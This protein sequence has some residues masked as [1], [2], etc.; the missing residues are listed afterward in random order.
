[1]RSQR[2]PGKP[3]VIAGDRPLVEW[4]V[5]AAQKSRHCH[6]FA[7]LTPADQ[8]HRFKD[9]AQRYQIATSEPDIP[10]GSDRVAAW[11]RSIPGGPDDVFVN[12]QCDEPDITGDD[13]DVLI[14]GLIRKRAAFATLSCPLPDGLLNDANTVKVCVDTTQQAVCFSRSPLD[15]LFGTP[16][17]HV[18]VYAFRRWM[19]QRFSRLGKSAG[20]KLHSLEQLRL[21]DRGDRIFVFHRPSVR[22]AINTSIDLQNFNRQWHVST[23][24]AA[25]A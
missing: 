8:V 15:V 10:T 20:E 11:A 19:L 16:R 4:A 12:L 24:G 13:L 25:S 7:I 21:H 14:D 17:Q 22:R 3:L 1:M 23:S 6:Q 5:G 18:G 2:L 9:L